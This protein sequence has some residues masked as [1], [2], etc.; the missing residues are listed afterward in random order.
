MKITDNVLMLN[1][2]YRGIINHQSGTNTLTT[3]RLQFR[4]STRGRDLIVQQT[5]KEV[6]IILTRHLTGKVTGRQLVLVALGGLGGQAVGLLLKQTQSVGLV[7]LLAIGA[8]DLVVHPLPE[9]RPG[10]FGGSGILLL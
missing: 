8:G 3:R 10:H 5:G 1:V 4:R 6:R 7:D 2:Q 9:L